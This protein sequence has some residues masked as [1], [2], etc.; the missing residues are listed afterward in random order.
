MVAN[1]RSLLRLIIKAARVI[2]NKYTNTCGCQISI[3]LRR[4]FFGHPVDKQFIGNLTGTVILTISTWWLNLWAN[5]QSVHIVFKKF[6]RQSTKFWVVFVMK[7]RWI[8]SKNS[9]SKM[10]HGRVYT[11]VFGPGLWSSQPLGNFP[12]LFQVEV[13]AIVRCT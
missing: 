12:S 4:S 9:S 11:G 6:I 2:Y 8:I 7:P 1:L 5:N 3:L 10:V 13:H